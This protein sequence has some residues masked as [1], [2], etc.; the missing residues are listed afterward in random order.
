MIRIS[1]TVEIIE[2]LLTINLTRIEQKLEKNNNTRIATVIF[3]CFACIF[4][5]ILILILF[6]YLQM[7][8]GAIL[9]YIIDSSGDVLISCILLYTAWTTIAVFC[10]LCFH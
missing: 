8:K 7:H 6:E 9:R 4:R 5:V 1:F 2:R 10:T 3:V